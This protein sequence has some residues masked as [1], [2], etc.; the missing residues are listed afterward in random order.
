[1]SQR[2][3]CRKG[4]I[5]IVYGA[6]NTVLDVYRCHIPGKSSTRIVRRAAK[7][8]NKVIVIC[9]YRLH[10]KSSFT[11]ILDIS[12]NICEIRYGGDHAQKNTLAAKLSIYSK[13]SSGLESE[14][15]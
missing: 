13:S 3:V 11:D 9:Y 14:N 8:C 10:W 15:K 2:V 6:G 7:F 1:M 12:L 4:N 5:R